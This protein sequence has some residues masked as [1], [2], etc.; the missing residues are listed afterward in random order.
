M[1]NVASETARGKASSSIF[2][3]SMYFLGG[4]ALADPPPPP[5]QHTHTPARP[6]LFFVTIHLS[7]SVLQ[8]LECAKMQFTVHI[9]I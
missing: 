7:H 8:L 9:H 2:Y 5:L 6:P 1:L 3:R 4:Q